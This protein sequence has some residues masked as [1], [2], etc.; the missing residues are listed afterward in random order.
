MGDIVE[1]MRPGLASRPLTPTGGGTGT[2]IRVWL[3]L[4][5]ALA[6][7]GATAHAGYDFVAA[8]DGDDN[9]E[10]TYARLCS[11][12]GAV[13]ACPHGQVC[14]VQLQAGLYLDPEVNIYYHRTISLIGDCED[15]HAVIFRATKPGRARLY[16]GSRHR[17]GELPD[18]RGHSAR[19]GRR[20]QRAPAHHCR[21]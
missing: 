7:G 6:L 16:S 21:L 2:A 18:T 4:L 5:F 1:T 19:R 8:P 9:G 3:G 20:N 11:P 13:N 12:Q 10:C 15:P 17:H 14:T